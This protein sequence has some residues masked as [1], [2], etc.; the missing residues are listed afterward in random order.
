MQN[1][2][3]VNCGLVNHINQSIWL[4][5]WLMDFGVGLQRWPSLLILADFAEAVVH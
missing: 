3:T 4:K 1:Y 2:N 5:D